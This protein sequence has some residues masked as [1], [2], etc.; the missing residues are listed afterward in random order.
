M[1]RAHKEE[2]MNAR[3][4]YEK[5]CKG[6][7]QGITGAYRYKECGLDNITVRN[8]TV[9]TC[10]NCGAVVP[11]IPAIGELHRSIAL[12]LIHKQTQLTGAEIR[13]LRKM[14]GMTPKDMSDALGVHPTSLC[15]WETGERKPAKKTDASIR[16]IAL[17]GMLQDMFK[18]RDLLPQVS[19]A[20]KEL[21]EVDIKTILARIKKGQAKPVKM[22]ID[23]N[24]L[25]SFGSFS[26]PT[27]G[28]ET[29]Q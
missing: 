18:E 3:K 25:A 9:Y 4:C 6:V 7:M 27:D 20:A 11:E 24:V 12:S 8:I 5:N 28:P 21:S 2:K 29:V 19:K 23:P 10:G 26:A 13:F 14:A 16:L 1:E 22:N 15:K 17:A